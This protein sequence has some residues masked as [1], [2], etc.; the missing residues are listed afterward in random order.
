MKRTEALVRR[1]VVTLWAVAL[2]ALW[3]ITL[4]ADIGRSAPAFRAEDQDGR[5]VKLSDFTGKIVVLE[6]LNPECPFVRRHAEAGTMHELARRYR[7][8]GVVW[9]G[10][11][12][13]KSS[14][15]AANRAWALKNKLDYPILDDASSAI[16]R[17]YGAKATPHMFV[18]DAGGRLAYAGAIDD[19]RDGEKGEKR[20]NY[21]EQALDELLA[22]R[23]V[24]VPE[25]A[26]YGCPVK[27]R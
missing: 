12:T 6:W 4:H 11:N 14:D 7:E 24:S 23:A 16:G 2:L 19:D 8:K 27:Y 5:T 18:I 22:G 17:A 26:A 15:A 3:S 10:V 25:T 20:V 9:L 1:I 13:S 21:V